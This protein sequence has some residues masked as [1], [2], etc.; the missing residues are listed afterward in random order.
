[1]SISVQTHVQMHSFLTVT[2][3][4]QSNLYSGNTQVS[5]I[6]R[7]VPIL[8][9]YCDPLWIVAPMTVCPQSDEMDAACSCSSHSEQLH[10]ITCPHNLHI[11]PV[12]AL[13][14]PNTS[15]CHKWR[16]EW[17][18]CP[19]HVVWLC[20]WYPYCAM[21]WNLL[22]AIG[23]AQQHTNAFHRHTASKIRMPD[24]N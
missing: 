2:T 20:L 8:R 12:D 19:W 5:I 9:C 1:M 17:R 22:V 7:S 11:T 23:F 13:C 18:D 4:K 14:L 10:N 24:E 15:K 6:L 16:E 3:T 21:K